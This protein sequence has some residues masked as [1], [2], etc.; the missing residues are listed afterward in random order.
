MIKIKIDS[1]KC[2]G[3]S[4]CLYHCPKNLIKK[5]KKLNKKGIYVVKFDDSSGECIGCKQCA[6][7]CPEQAIEVIDDEN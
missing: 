3:C 6:I 5:S 1:E 7:M 4:L 2:K